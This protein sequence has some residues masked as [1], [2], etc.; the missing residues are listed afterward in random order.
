ME[1]RLSSHDATF[2]PPTDSSNDDESEML[3]PA[4][5]LED[6]RFDPSI[7]VEDDE[8]HNHGC[9]QLENGLAQLDERSQDILRKRWLADKKVTLQELAKFYGVSAERIR[10]VESNALKKLK[11]FLKNKY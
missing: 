2:D 3:T 1:S 10:Q 7:M 9:N 4:A 6:N 8:W 5:Y 11:K